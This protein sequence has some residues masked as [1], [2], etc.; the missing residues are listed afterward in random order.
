MTDTRDMA[1][2][3]GYGPRRPGVF[4][5]DRLLAYAL[6][7][8]EDAE[9]EQAAAGDVELA[10]RLEAVRRDVALIERQVAGAV[11]A[12]ADDYADLAGERWA[13]L[14]E[15]MAPRPEKATRRRASRWLRVAVPVAAACALA[16]FAGLTALERNGD[17]ASTG[18][19][20]DSAQTAR[21]PEA[22][23]AVRSAQA[24]SFA[25][26]LDE[27]RVVVL[28]RAQAVTGALQ[29]FSVVRE[30]KGHTP[31][32]IRLAVGDTPALVDRLHLLLLDPKS[33]EGLD[34]RL[35]PACLLYT[36]DAADE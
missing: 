13:G 8:D 11:P 30:L 15:L 4:D 7:L 3:D 5:D 24:M 28:A 16:A 23:S 34:E 33:E 29:R 26:E 35:G 19:A 22:G 12:P 32:S 36:S 9:L 27:F 10:G 17:R 14:R 31:D 20:S 18:A 1:E 21:A 25:E 2:P 6:A